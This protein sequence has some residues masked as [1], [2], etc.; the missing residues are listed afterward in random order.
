MFEDLDIIPTSDSFG[1][2]I[3]L[4]PDTNSSKIIKDN[5]TI[6]RTESSASNVHCIISLIMG[7][8]T[9]R[10]VLTIEVEDPITPDDYESQ[11]ISQSKFNTTFYDDKKT[12]FDTTAHK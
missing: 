2:K 9:H 3:V 10:N 1:F 8:S 11:W 6:T 7:L 5:D 12:F 4:N